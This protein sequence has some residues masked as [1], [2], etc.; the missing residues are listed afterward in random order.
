M[1]EVKPLIIERTIDAPVARV[2]KALTDSNDLKQWLPFF[3]DFKA[4]VGF[5]TE[6]ELGP[7]NGEQYHHV[8]E[9]LEVVEGQKLSY[10]WDY[11]GMSDGSSV[12]F[13]L[14]ADGDKTHLVLTGHFAAIPTDIPD[15]TENAVKG[16]NYTA[17]G[18]KQFAEA[19]K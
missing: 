19:S 18:L 6:F 13:E 3:P 11:G 5:R 7:S 15:F 16:W 2:W 8:V 1:A 17:D 9:V 10:S 14:A 4:K 12:T